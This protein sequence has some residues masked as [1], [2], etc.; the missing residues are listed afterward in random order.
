MSFKCRECPEGADPLHPGDA[1]ITEVQHFTCSASSVNFQMYHRGIST[2]S[3]PAAASSADIEQALNALPSL[4]DLQVSVGSSPACSALSVTFVS[5]AGSQALLAMI[6]YDS[7][8]QGTTL[9]ATRSTTGTVHSDQRLILRCSFD[10]TASSKGFRFNVSSAEHSALTT[11]LN[12]S[13]SP[14]MLLSAL[15]DVS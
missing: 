3:L 10:S 15:E 8:G 13:S 1:H 7:G 9:I 12:P 2:A 5:S 11:Y 4:T 14:A 6:A